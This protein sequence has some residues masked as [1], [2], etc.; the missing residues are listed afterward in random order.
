M[1][2]ALTLLGFDLCIC[3]AVDPVSG[4]NGSVAGTSGTDPRAH[5]RV[6]VPKTT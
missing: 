2:S 5:M 1:Y 6:S 3:S 4:S